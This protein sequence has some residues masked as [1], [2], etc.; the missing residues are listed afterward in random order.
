MS[1]NPWEHLNYFD[2]AQLDRLLAGAGFF[3]IPESELSGD[4]N[5]GLRRDAGFTAR[6]GNACASGLR[7]A[8]YAFTGEAVRSPNR[9]F[10][11]F[12]E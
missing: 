8:R 2:L 9:A 7:L 1:F 11:R 12:S 5:I 4:V 3:P 10:Y 6:L